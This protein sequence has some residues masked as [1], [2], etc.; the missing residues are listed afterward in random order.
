M[1]MLESALLLFL[2]ID[3]FGNL[4]V[5]LAVVGDAPAAHYRRIIIRETALAFVVLALFAYAGDQVLGYLNIER[6]SLT[7]AGGVIL[8]LISL[9]MVF[10][11]A[12]DLFD[13]NYRNDPLLFPIAVPLLAGPSAITTVMILRSQ[14]QVD[15]TSLLLVLAAVLVVTCIV[16]LPGRRLST[17]LGPRGV[18]ALEKLMGLLLNLVAVNMMLVGVRTFF[19]V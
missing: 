6:A 13:E 5:V 14:Q 7:V 15:L 18:R 16:F 9:K 19:T 10:R 2:V 8:F 1:R 11:S 4:P 12:A 17:H 3:P